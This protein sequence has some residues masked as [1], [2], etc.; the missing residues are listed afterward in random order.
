MIPRLHARNPFA[1]RLDDPSAFVTKHNG[2]RALGVFAGERVSI[3]TRSHPSATLTHSC[4]HAAKTT[5]GQGT[6]KAEEVTGMTNSGVV[7]LDADFVGPRR[8]D[9]DILNDEILPGLPGDGGLWSNINDCL[10]D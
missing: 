7:N 4:H 10:P 5:T 8:L 9:F 1:N 3:C 6:S 2:E